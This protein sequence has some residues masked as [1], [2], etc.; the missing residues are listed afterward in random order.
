MANAAARATAKDKIP[1]RTVPLEVRLVALS[2]SASSVRRCHAHART[3]ARTH[4]RQ[5]RAIARRFQ[6][7]TSKL[8]NREDWAREAAFRVKERAIKA[9]PEALRK[10]AL[11]T[12]ERRL[13][14]AMAVPANLPKPGWLAMPK[15]S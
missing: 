1:R 10:D 9:L 12:E 8:Q 5:E 4:T 14:A 3:H 6:V 7:E 13:A 15:P 11:L 2:S